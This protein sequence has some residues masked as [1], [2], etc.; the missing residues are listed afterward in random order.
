MRA[1]DLSRSGRVAPEKRAAR[2]L[3][4]GHQAAGKARKPFVV[5]LWQ[6][7]R[8]K[9]RSRRRACGRKV[10]QIDGEGLVADVLGP[11]AGQKVRAHG[12]HVRRHRNA[13]ARHVDDGAVVAHALTSPLSERVMREE[14][15]DDLK[16][17]ASHFSTSEKKARFQEKEPLPPK[18]TARLWE[19][20]RD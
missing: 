1:A 8:E 11:G 18:G 7:D 9:E 10:R 13:V 20:V 19:S 4:K 2:A 16:F 6:S 17:S 12:H 5:T 14:A 3:R 15:V